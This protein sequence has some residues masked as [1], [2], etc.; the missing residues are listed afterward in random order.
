ML[1]RTNILAMAAALAA[2]LAGCA[3]SSIRNPSASAAVRGIRASIDRIRQ[4]NAHIFGVALS[5]VSSGPNGYGYG[6]RYGE[7]DERPAQ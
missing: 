5:K 7:A 1:R 3:G 4:S 6:Q 2:S